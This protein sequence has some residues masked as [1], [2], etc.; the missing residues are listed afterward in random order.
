[1]MDQLL[2]ALCVHYLY[3]ILKAIFH[4]EFLRLK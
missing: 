4:L 1:M 2:I 3:H